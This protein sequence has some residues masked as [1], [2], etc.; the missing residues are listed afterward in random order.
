MHV[1]GADKSECATKTNKIFTLNYGHHR[2]CLLLIYRNDGNKKRGKKKEMEGRTTA[3][4]A[5]ARYLH[6]ALLCGGIFNLLI[7]IVRDDRSI[8]LEKLI[9]SSHF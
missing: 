2:R 4:A 6:S 7:Y 5:Y 3:Y 9:P 1:A 8:C